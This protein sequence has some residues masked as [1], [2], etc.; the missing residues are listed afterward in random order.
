MPSS[1]PP[2]PAATYG[3]YEGDA[4]SVTLN[5]VQTRSSP[6]A[7]GITCTNK[8]ASS[9]D[10]TA[11]SATVTIPANAASHTF[12]IQTTEDTAVEVQERFNIAS[13]P[14]GVVSSKLHQSARVTIYNDGELPDE[15]TTGGAYITIK[16]TLSTGVTEGGGL[17][18]LEEGTI[19]TVRI[20][21]DPVPAAPIAVNYYVGDGGDHIAAG[22]SGY[23]SVTIPGARASST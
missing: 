11:C 10:Y 18:T 21:Q 2:T 23:R 19:F 4:V 16:G 1:S 5:I 12:D 22:N 17:Y 20:R 8:T 13:V 14:S 7:V 3:A 15:F 9:S 6:T